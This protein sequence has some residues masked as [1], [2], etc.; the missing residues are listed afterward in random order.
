MP[1][2]KLSSFDETCHLITELRKNRRELAK[3]IARLDAGHWVQFRTS[4]NYQLSEWLELPRD[5]YP[6]M[7]PVFR[8]IAAQKLAAVESQLKE[9]GI[10]IDE[11]ALPEN[12]RVANLQQSSIRTTD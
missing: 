7:R 11:P 1:D 8:N 3:L 12:F 6:A 4:G 9:L 2:I 10:A 5:E